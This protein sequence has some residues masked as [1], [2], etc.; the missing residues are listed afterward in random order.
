MRLHPL[1]LTLLLATPVAAD[2]WTDLEPLYRDLHAHPELSE[3]EV[4][5]AAKLAAR[6]R[7]LGFT[8]TEKVGGTGIVGILEN[9]EGPVVMLR[10][11]LD[12]LPV[13]EQTGLAYA[14][15]APGVMH[16]CGHD[17]HMTAW[18]GAA[19][20]LAADRKSWSGT[21][22]M[23]GQP[24][25]EIGKGA[26]AML[27]D[28]LFT[29]FPK[30]AAAI[31]LHNNDRLPAGVVGIKPGPMM[32]SADSVDITVFGRGGHG[33]QPHTTID[34]IVIA[35][36][37]VLGLQVLV[38]RENDPLEPV[39]VTVGSIHGGTRPNIIP[40]DVKLELTLRAFQPQVRD[41]LLAGVERVA[42][43]EAVAAGAVKP[44]AVTVASVALATSSDDRLAALVE[45]ALL[46]T[47]GK[48]RVV[49]ARPVM[50]A[51]DF[52]HYGAAGVPILLMWIGTADP[53][54][55]AEATRNGTTLPGL[56]SAQFAPVPRATILGGV[57]A[58]VTAAKAIFRSRR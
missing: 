27:K 51:E 58:H 18:T 53:D 17:V 47:L 52:S 43:A 11:E 37:I 14:S 31:A 28:G 8:V 2:S 19:A 25:E 56:H 46:S 16:A 1:A 23:V 22:M 40:D 5:T 49:V 39:V 41:R 54:A 48:Q 50:P 55:L 21:L 30:P 57:E 15:T 32:P 9:G 12:A 26:E 3:K 33:A 44:P 36:K 45:P 7:A 6:L 4:A 29:R 35:A 42:K 10:T 13:E 38:S 20:A 34:P 24:A